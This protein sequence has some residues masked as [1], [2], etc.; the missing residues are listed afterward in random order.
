MDVEV[1]YLHRQCI[2]AAYTGLALINYVNYGHILMLSFKK[3]ARTLDTKAKPLHPIKCLVPVTV[4]GDKNEYRKT[5]T[6]CGLMTS[7]NY[8]RDTHSWL[9]IIQFDIWFVHNNDYIRT[10]H[11]TQNLQNLSYIYMYMYIY[12][13]IYLHKFYIWINNADLMTRAF[14]SH[15][16][17]DTW[18]IN[19]IYEQGKKS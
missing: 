17:R 1:S 10:R 15:R 6:I 3:S 2:G 11:I 4:N 12:E 5:G 14:K 7:S 18:C 8:Q 19:P 13:Y 16:Y 9:L